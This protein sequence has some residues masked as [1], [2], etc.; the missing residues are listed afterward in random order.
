MRA[1]AF[2]VTSSW[3]GRAPRGTQAAQRLERMRDRQREQQADDRQHHQREARRQDVVERRHR[4]EMGPERV[5]VRAGRVVDRDPGAERRVA[6]Q[7]TDDRTAPGRP[8]TAATAR[9]RC[10]VSRSRPAS[11]GT[12]SPPAAPTAS[13]CATAIAPPRHGRQRHE[14]G[15]RRPVGELLL[16]EREPV[17]VAGAGELVPHRVRQQRP[18]RSG[19]MM[20]VPISIGLTAPR[21]TAGRHDRVHDDE[22]QTGDAR[23]RAAVPR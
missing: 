14:R 18:G 2:S 3:C 17:D 6:E 20:P 16:V 10:R 11:R 23:C 7:D 22:D 13:D 4:A 5:R 12:S 19:A 9:P 15:Q 1:C 8:V 21:T